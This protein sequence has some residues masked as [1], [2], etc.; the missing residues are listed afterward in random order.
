M[1]GFWANHK[2][3]TALNSSVESTTASPKPLKSL[4]HEVGMALASIPLIPKIKAELIALRV[5]MQGVP[6]GSEDQYGSHNNASE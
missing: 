3:P 1:K 4:H 5:M 6:T 2:A